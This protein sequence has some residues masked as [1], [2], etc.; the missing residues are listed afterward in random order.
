MINNA[1]TFITADL[2]L[3]LKSLYGLREN[4]AL[5]SNIVNP[6]GSIALQE[7]NRLIISLVNMEQERT[8]ATHGNYTVSDKGGV[9]QTNPPVHLNLY[10]MFSAYFKGGNY[11]EALKFLSGVVS[12]FQGKNVFT[13][14]NSPAL[15]DRIDKLSA[16]LVKHSTQELSH[17]WGM[18]GA[19]Y[20]PS[21]TYKIK[22][23]TIQ[24]GLIT[25]QAPA[26]KGSQP[27]IYKQ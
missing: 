13:H 9:V 16:E 7:D 8:V 18:L 1:L 17:L 27:D 12:F 6:D 5:L 20:M 11:P 3:H 14:H 24:Q 26:I 23:L 21:V 4:V 19:K 22:M 2:N 25:S 10:V 15:D